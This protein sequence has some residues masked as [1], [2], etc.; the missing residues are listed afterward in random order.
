M[1]PDID[2]MHV[3][4][5]RTG[6]VVDG[7]R[8]NVLTESARIARGEIQDVKDVAAADLDALIL[9]GG[10]GAAKNLCTFATEGSACSVQEDVARL[11]RDV[12]A[13]GKPLGA[14]CIAPALVAKILEGEPWAAKL[15]IGNDVGTANALTS[16]KA[17][18]VDCPVGDCV[19]DEEHKI[20]TSPAYMLAGSIKEAAEGIEKSVRAVLDLV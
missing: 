19:V 16:M 18:H 20:V 8:R 13:A 1:A 5:H 6:E 2:Q 7:E 11:V 12:V 3:I 15:T 10:F 9:P 17:A 14:V 4:D